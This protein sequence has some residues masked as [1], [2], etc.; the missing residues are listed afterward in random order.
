MEPSVRNCYSGFTIMMDLG[1]FC[2]FRC[3]SL[4]FSRVVYWRYMVSTWHSRLYGTWVWNKDLCVEMRMCCY[5]MEKEEGEGK[6]N[7]STVSIDQL[8]D[9]VQ[10]LTEAH[11]TPILLQ[12]I[13]FGNMILYDLG[14]TLLPLLEVIDEGLVKNNS[15]VRWQTRKFRKFHSAK[16]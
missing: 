12:T 10:L 4:C 9:G 2:C 16:W 6:R 1:Y 14:V 5:A 15:C 13:G 8:V 3:L 7:G 11:Q